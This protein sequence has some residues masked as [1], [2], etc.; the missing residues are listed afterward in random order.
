MIIE[1]ES[2]TNTYLFLLNGSDETGAVI[3]EDDDSGTNDNSQLVL[4]LVRGTY[5]I[6]ATTFSPAA[7]GEFIVS[8]DASDS[9]SGACSNSININTNVSG[10]WVAECESEHD[11]KSVV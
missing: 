4:G 8:I 2:S 1:L 9:P 11:R 3:R 10:N 7:T 6:E 5:T